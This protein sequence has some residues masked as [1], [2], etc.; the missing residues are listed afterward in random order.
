[1]AQSLPKS[2]PLTNRVLLVFLSTDA[3]FPR[4]GANKLLDSGRMTLLRFR[5]GDAHRNCTKP[6]AT[7]QPRTAVNRPARLIAFVSALGPLLAFGCV[8]LF[9]TVADAIF[10]DGTFGTIHNLRTI[11]VGTSGIAVAA[12][13]MTLIII[14]GG[15]DLSIGTAL[16]LSAT[17]LSVCLRDGRGPFIAV[18]ACIGVGCLA[19]FVNGVLISTLK[20]VP[21]I[22]TLGTMSVYFGLGKLVADETT[23]RPRPEQ[24]PQWLPDLLQIDPEPS[25]LLVST[26]VWFAL[27]LAVMT[28]CILRFTVFGRYV[29]ALGSNEAA[30]RLCG[31]N[32]SRTKIAVYTLSGFFAG[33]AGLYNFGRLTQGDP[34]AGRG[35]ELGIIA[36][37]VIGGTSLSGGRG[38]VLGT[39]AGAAIIRA[40]TSGCTQLGLKNSYQDIVLGAIIIAAVVVDQ[41][42]QRR[43]S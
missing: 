32:V 16:A 15:I 40:I 18:A 10:A 4:S 1:M 2:P 6:M 34:T 8:L 7:S 36:A 13:G 27:V 21:F 29:I 30:A 24:V 17:V 5:R 38:S 26:G 37:V 12:L 41:L 31:I 43:L 39:L 11:A 35:A 23:V 28:A 9:F 19:G 25:W 42:R 33:I 22:V 3:V 20:V 14:S